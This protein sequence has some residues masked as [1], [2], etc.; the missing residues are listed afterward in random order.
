MKLYIENVD[1]SNIFDNLRQSD[2]EELLLRCR[3]TKKY[4]DKYLKLYFKYLS[5]EIEKRKKYNK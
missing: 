3:I 2:F 1:Y 5:L 4:K